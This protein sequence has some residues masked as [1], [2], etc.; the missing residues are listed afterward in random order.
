MDPLMK[1]PLWNDAG[2]Q[3][4]APMTRVSLERAMSACGL[5]AALCVVAVILAGCTTT[6]GA[7]GAFCDTAK[8]FRPTEQSVA[9]MSDPEVEE[10]LAH[11]KHGERSCGWRP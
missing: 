10:A 3:N 4:A 8:P 11:N 6:G 9:A 2:E 5:L 7:G 1:T